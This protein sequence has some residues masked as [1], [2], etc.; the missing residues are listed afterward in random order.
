MSRDKVIVSI[1]CESVMEEEVIDH[2]KVLLP[3]KDWKFEAD[4][5]KGFTTP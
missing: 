1:T 3:A 5:C 4:A 2:Y